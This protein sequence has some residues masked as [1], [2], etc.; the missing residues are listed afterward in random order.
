MSIKFYSLVNKSKKNESKS[1]LF[2]YIKKSNS[3]LKNWFNFW[4]IFPVECGTQSKYEAFR[5]LELAVNY[6]TKTFKQFDCL[7]FLKKAFI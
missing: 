6:K 3:K 4:I 1:H 5:A 7:K 2:Q